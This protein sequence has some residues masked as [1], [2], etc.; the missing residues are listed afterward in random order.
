[1]NRSMKQYDPIDFVVDWVDSNDISWKKKKSLYEEN[2]ISSVDD[3]QARYRDWGI[4]K[5]WFRAVEKNAPWVHKIFIITDHQNP[6]FLNKHSSKIVFVNHED[7]IPNEYLPTFNSDAIEI[8]IQNIPGL[9]EHFVFFND[10]MFINKPVKPIDFFDGNIP[11]DSGVMGPQFPISNSITH[12]TVNNME[13]INK[14]FL[15]KKVLRKYFFK[16]FN[17]RYGKDNIRTATALPWQV[18][19]G[20]YDMHIP[21]SF[22]K[23]TF[24]NVWSEVGN[25]LSQ[26]YQHRF[27]SQL[28]YSVWLMR[29]FQLASGNFFPRRTRFG[30]YYNLGEQTEEIINDIKT[31]KHALIVL[32]DQESINDYPYEKKLVNEVFERRYSRKSE[33]EN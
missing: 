27:R 17:W 24:D 2:V 22:L 30:K 28:D 21:I 1:M 8:G 3:S 23:S 26:N 32:N 19:I 25:L 14:Y 31:G 12:I 6:K 7:F 18:F 20:F 15:K 33:F 4:F 16:F 5:Y 11:K 13:I 29:Y 9:S 10:D